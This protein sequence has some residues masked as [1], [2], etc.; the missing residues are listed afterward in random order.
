MGWGK[1]WQ[2]KWFIVLPD[3]TSREN[4]L[5]VGFAS[6]AELILSVCGDGKFWYHLQS[7]K[8]CDDVSCSSWAIV[9]LDTMWAVNALFW[10]SDARRRS[11]V[12]W[13]QPLLETEGC[14]S[15][16]LDMDE[17][18]CNKGLGE[19]RRGWRIAW[20]ECS[21]SRLVNCVLTFALY[22][23]SSFC[24]GQEFLA[25]VM[26]SWQRPWVWPMSV[27]TT[28]VIFRSG[29]GSTVFL[30]SFKNME[31]WTRYPSV[32]FLM[33]VYMLSDRKVLVKSC[34]YLRRPF[35]V[36]W[37]PSRKRLSEFAK[38]TCLAAKG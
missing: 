28:M 13:S 34:N 12:T 11:W 23:G 27:A 2:S 25:D 9:S 38:V 26:E 22:Y 36:C 8:S 19:L 31:R 29:D 7:C 3:F 20:T 32:L 30:V 4:P 24:W 10:F 5:A 17:S 37:E 14:S 33:Y 15:S 1:T 16:S 21:G 35:M 6:C 18:R